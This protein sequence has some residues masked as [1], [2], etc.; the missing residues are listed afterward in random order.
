MEAGF[1]NQHLVGRTSVPRLWEIGNDFGNKC[2]IYGKFVLEL[3][4]G[5]N[6]ADDYPCGEWPCTG[7]GRGLELGSFSLGAGGSWLC[8][9]RAA[10][11]EGE[12]TPSAGWHHPAGAPGVL[13]FVLRSLPQGCTCK[14]REWKT[15]VDQLICG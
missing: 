1:A 13:G 6:Q 4:I 15:P 5:A 7:E 8:L 11:P 9:L 2:W 12:F 10:M 3:L 14:R